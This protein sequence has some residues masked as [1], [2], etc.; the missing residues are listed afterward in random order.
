[1]AAIYEILKLK[2]LC[3]FIFFYTFVLSYASF[4][5]KYCSSYRYFNKFISKLFHT[6]PITRYLGY[7][8]VMKNSTPYMNVFTKPFRFYGNETCS[9]PCRCNY[10]C[11][12]KFHFFKHFFFYAYFE[13]RYFNFIGCP[14]PTNIIT[15][16]TNFSVSSFT[17]F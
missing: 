2:D 3:F 1:M 12:F 4:A 17:Y 9:H 14:D 11:D 16:L 10:Y 8:T 13:F 5:L 15:F 7:I 6:L